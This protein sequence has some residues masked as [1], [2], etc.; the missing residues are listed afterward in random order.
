VGYWRRGAETLLVAWRGFFAH[1]RDVEMREHDEDD[2]V[3]RAGLSS[4]TQRI[5]RSLTGNRRPLKGRR[6]EEA[7]ASPSRPMTGSD[8]IAVDAAG[9]LQKA[10]AGP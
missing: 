6:P 8:D 5:A 10:G 1:H 7:P 9:D 2:A 3:L 4:I